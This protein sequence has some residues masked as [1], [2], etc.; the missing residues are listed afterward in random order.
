MK[1]LFTLVVAAFAALTISAKEDI[2][3]SGILTDG[4]VNFTGQWQWK[5]INYGSTDD[6]GKDV[7]ADKSAFKYVVVEYTSGTCGEVNLIAQY[8]KDGTT[9]QYGDNYYTTTGGGSV[10]PGGGIL[11][12]ELDS[13]HSKTMNAVAFQ[14]KGTTGTLTIKSAYFASKE[15]YEA[16]KAEADKIEKI[17]SLEEGKTHTLVA[18]KWGWDQNWLG[19]SVEDFNTLVF[20]IS[21]IAGKAKV[22]IQG[23]LNDNTESKDNEIVFDSNES[24]VYTFDI[25]NFKTLNVYAFQNLNKP[26]GEGYGEQD[27]EE[28]TIVVT[29]VYLT[30]K[31]ADEITSNI[32]NA[33]V[34]PK[35]NVNAPI[36]NLAG[37]QVTKSYKGVVILNGKKF[38]QK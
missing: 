30:S 3:V 9:G 15:E 23:I 8:E 20:E 21:S 26:D 14:N 7:Y 27:I 11:A 36:Y 13:E 32:S 16:A 2:D 4:V 18:K 5:G 25:S 38:V 22:G 37:Q 1:K 6:A 17:S 31:K 33:F 19:K 12:V 34:A 35:A 28:T 29:K 24:K 10:N